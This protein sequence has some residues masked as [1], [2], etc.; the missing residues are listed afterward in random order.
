MDGRPHLAVCFLVQRRVDQ[1]VRVLGSNVALNSITTEYEP[2]SNT[3]KTYNN[4]NSKVTI[5]TKVFLLVNITTE[6]TAVTI[7]S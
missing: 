5:L 4:N 3:N 2:F 6:T 1:H 7:L